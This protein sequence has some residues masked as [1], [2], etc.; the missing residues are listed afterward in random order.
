MNQY[1]YLEL[2]S[3]HYANP[4]TSYQ[5]FPANQSLQNNAFTISTNLGNSFVRS[6][7]ISSSA[8]S[9]DG[10]RDFVSNGNN[11]NS[12]TNY[13]RTS[14]LN[15]STTIHQSVLDESTSST[16]NNRDVQSGQQYLLSSI[17][18]CDARR[19][20]LHTSDENCQSSDDAESLG[21]Q[22]TNSINNN[23]SAPQSGFVSRNKKNPSLRKGKW[24][25]EEERYTNKVIETFNAGILKLPDTERGVTLRAYL[26]EK[27]GCDPMRITK[28]YTG[29]SCLGK[30]VYH[31]DTIHDNSPDVQRARME[32]EIL[33]ANF[34]LKLEQIT[35]R[36][37]TNDNSYINLNHSNIISSPAIDA[38]VMQGRCNINPDS[39]ININGV[40][41]HVQ[42]LPNNL[43]NTQPVHISNNAF[44]RSG[45]SDRLNYC[46]TTADS[47]GHPNLSTLNHQ[48]LTNMNQHYPEIEDKQHGR[49]LARQ[50]VNQ[51]DYMY[52]KVPNIVQQSNPNPVEKIISSI[53]RV[54]LESE[55]A[56]RI[57]DKINLTHE[58][59][60]VINVDFQEEEVDHIT[61][62]I[63]I[64]ESDQNAAANSL[65]GFF[66]HLQ[67]IGSK[68]DFVE[69]FEGVQK[70]VSK[71]KSPPNNHGDNSFSCVP[72]VDHKYIP[73]GSIL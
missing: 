46:T 71:T 57:T 70:T 3:I 41:F 22:K 53:P 29:A 14:S 5:Q 33:E 23:M 66:N 44:Q 32:L 60:Q 27:L 19:D 61:K 11:N 51:S 13:N 65:L 55:A 59:S 72:T 25:I 68:E 17:E 36:K 62:K 38:L 2:S 15:V 73:L 42:M 24:T 18:G 43:D 30:R 67:K 56:L 47:S 16:D 48:G 21:A 31:P 37:N 40:K 34:R 8:G 54:K 7:S 4:Q 9:F 45:L 6:N 64:S 12:A 20:S 50:Y 39:S 69:F 1:Q 35:R 28:K 63:K 49:N 26:S 52:S 10:K 58:N